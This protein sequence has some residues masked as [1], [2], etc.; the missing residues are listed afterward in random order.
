VIRIGPEVE[1]SQPISELA[2]GAGR[3]RVHLPG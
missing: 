2:G 3:R 1:G